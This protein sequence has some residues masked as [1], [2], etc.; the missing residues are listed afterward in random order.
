MLG[1]LTGVTLLQLIITYPICRIYKRAGYSW[2]WGLFTLIPLIGIAIIPGALGF[3]KWPNTTNEGVKSTGKHTLYWVAIFSAIFLF[4][5]PIEIYEQNIGVITLASF[6]YIF[7][8]VGCICV[9]AGYSKWWGILGLLM[10]T[11]LVWPWILAF[12]KWP[13][14]NQR[15]ASKQVDNLLSVDGTG[16]DVR[17]KTS[18]S[19]TKNNDVN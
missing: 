6:V 19:H 8:G 16:I 17:S 9:N 12:S 13:A 7:T 1:Q 5:I 2:Y 14:L 3:V 10:I 15:T 11:N 18:F 4:G